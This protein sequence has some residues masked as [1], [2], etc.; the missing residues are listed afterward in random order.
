M[1]QQIKVLI[2]GRDSLIEAMFLHRGFQIVKE[3]GGD[4]PDLVQ[5][6]GGEDISPALYGHVKHPAT[7]T[8]PSR[9][10]YEVNIF[11]KYKGKVPLA[12]ICRGGQLLNVLS[13]GTMYQHVDQHG[14]YHLATDVETGRE[15]SVASTHHQMMIPGPDGQIIMVA[16]E[17]NVRWLEESKQLRKEGE[18]DIEAV[19]YGSTN[20]L[21]FQPHPEYVDLDH[22]GQEIYFEYLKKYNNI[23]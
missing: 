8:N 11:H 22:E 21:C 14:R 4:D 1:K 15:I 2:V 5:F 7:Y 20:A 19:Y 17:S 9:D 18:K 12:G 13:G 3:V 10:E 23:G 16:E 6:T